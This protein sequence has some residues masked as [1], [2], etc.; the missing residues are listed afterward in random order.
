MNTNRKLALVWRWLV[1]LTILCALLWPVHGYVITAGVAIAKAIVGIAIY[2]L[3]AGISGFCVGSVFFTIHERK[4]WGKWLIR[5]LTAKD[6]VITSQRH[7]LNAYEEDQQKYF[8]NLDKLN[9]ATWTAWLMLKTLG[10]ISGWSEATL[11]IKSLHALL[12]AKETL[13]NLRSMGVGNGIIFRHEYDSKEAAEQ[14]ALFRQQL[15]GGNIRAI[16]LADL[17]T[18]ETEIEEFEKGILQMVA[19]EEKNPLLKRRKI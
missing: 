19:N 1:A 3:I 5:W 8:K 7:L 4:I 6:K 14:L 17:G 13:K 15:R 18:D 10:E 12:V 11:N 9:D 2:L 16:H